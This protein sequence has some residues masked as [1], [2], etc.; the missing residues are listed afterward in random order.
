[1]SKIGQTMQKYRKTDF[2]ITCYFYNVDLPEKRLTLKSALNSHN[3]VIKFLGFLAQNRGM[4]NREVVT[5][6]Q[7]K[8]EILTLHA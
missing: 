3:N 1:M 4:Q 7:I 2:L 5:F 6:S 8:Y